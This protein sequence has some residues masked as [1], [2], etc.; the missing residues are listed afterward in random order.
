MAQN[1]FANFFASYLVV[2]D[3]LHDFLG[4]NR[5]TLHARPGPF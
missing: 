3:T 5:P 4:T 2:A 1:P